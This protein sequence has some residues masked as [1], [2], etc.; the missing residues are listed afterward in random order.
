[1]PVLGVVILF[2]LVLFVP[3]SLAGLVEAQERD[4]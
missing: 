1:M 4:A 3:L 2:A